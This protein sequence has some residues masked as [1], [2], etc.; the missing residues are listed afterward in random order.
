[1]K[2]IGDIDTFV[3]SVIGGAMAVVQGCFGIFW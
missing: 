1:M 2:L 3:V